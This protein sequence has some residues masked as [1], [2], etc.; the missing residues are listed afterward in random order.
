M[1]TAERHDSRRFGKVCVYTCITG[2][3]DGLST[4]PPGQDPLVD[5]ICFTDDP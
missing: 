2:G 3:Y 4:V 5:F 1:Q